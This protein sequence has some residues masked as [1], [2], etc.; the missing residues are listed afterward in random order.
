M[1]GIA[2]SSISEP[3][4]EPSSTTMISKEYGRGVE[5][6]PDAIDL[7]PEVPLLVVDGEDDADVELGRVRGRRHEPSTVARGD[8]SSRGYA[9]I[10]VK[11]AQRPHPLQ[12]APTGRQSPRS[13]GD[14]GI[15]H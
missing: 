10:V 9:A 8:R 12:I 13:E 2:G 4:F 3:S 11:S 15:H 5:R 7:G 14:N 6:G 1:S